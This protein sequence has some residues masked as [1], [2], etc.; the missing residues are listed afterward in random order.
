M[1]AARRPN[2]P[3][4]YLD[5]QATTPCDPR[6]VEAMLPY[7]T[8]KFGNPGSLTHAYGREAEEA[9][10]QARCQ[11]AELIGAEPRE[12]VFTSGATESN[13]LAVKGAA[14]FHR[15]FG[16]DH[17]VTLATEHKCVL[18]SARS[19]EA[20]GFRV[21][22]VPVGR[23]GLVDLGRLE[24][25]ISDQTSIVSVMAA[26]NE[27]GVIQPLKE[28]AALAHAKGALFHSDAAQAVGKMPLDV[29]DDRRSIC[30]R[31]PAT[32]ST[33]PRAWARFICAAARAP[34]SRR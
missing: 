19:L 25:A 14:H 17:I 30:C 28:I 11:L 24:A 15:Q 18:E 12:I 3:P 27:I 29:D 13:N 34:A 32:R 22:Y 8:E 31:S 9:V 23:D 10:E 4:V 26:H 7:F 2:A 5:Y 16:K 6:V 33:A 20:E 21:A 1:T